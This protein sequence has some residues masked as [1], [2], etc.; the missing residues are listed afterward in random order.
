MWQA[1]DADELQLGHP[2]TDPLL[3]GG[4]LGQEVVGDQV[5]DAPEVHDGQRSTH[6]EGDGR[7]P[8]TLQAIP[9]CQPCHPVNSRTPR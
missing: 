5:P 1:E 8:H 9:G 7:V 6:Q 3:D 2:Q 4:R